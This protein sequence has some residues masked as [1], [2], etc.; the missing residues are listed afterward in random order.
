MPV[1]VSEPMSQRLLWPS[2]QLGQRPHAGMKPNTTWSPATSENTPAPTSMTM[3]APSWPPISGGS[4]VAPARSPVTR[5]SSLWHMPLATILT[6][7]SPAFGGS[8]SISSTLQAVFRALRIAALVFTIAPEVVSGRL[9]RTITRAACSRPCE[10]PRHIVT[11]AGA[12][13]SPSPPLRRA[14]AAPRPH[15]RSRGRCSCR[16]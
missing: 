14:P 6:N 9:G 7:T 3:P 12:G 5:C 10:A 8:S 4:G 13:R 15:L 11:A 2:A 1:A 16:R